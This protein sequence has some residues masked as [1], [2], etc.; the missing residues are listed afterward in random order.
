MK[1]LDPPV[2]QQDYSAYAGRWIASIGDQIIG[3][4]GT[5]TQALRAAQS[6][7]YKEVPQ[8]SYVPPTPPLK[9]HPILEELASL[10]PPDTPVYVVGGAVRDALLK[11]QVT[12]LDFILQNNAIKQA[13]KVADHFGGAFYVLDGERDYGRAMIPQ[14]GSQTL[15]MDF[16]PFQGRDLET[17]LLLR[18][19]TINAVA[20]GI[21][22]PYPIHDP[23]GGV[24][25]MLAKRLRACSPTA[26]SS[27]PIRVL[28]GIRF[29]INYDLRAEKETK[30]QMKASA[31]M[32]NNSSAER[33]RDELFK[34]LESKKPAAAIE[35]LD[36]LGGLEFVLPELI[37]LK[38]INQSAPHI[39]DAWQ[40]TL[41]VVR[42]LRSIWNVLSTSY[43]PDSTSNLFMGVLTQRL[44]R[45]R[46]QL[47]DHLDNNLVPYRTIRAL[48]ILAALYHDSGKPK[49]QEIEK[50]G[51]ARFIN[52]EEQ[53]ANIISKR[54]LKLHL[55]NSEIKRLQTIVH[56]HM[57]PLWL[58]QSGDLPSRR[59]KFRFFHD[60]NA[61]GVD[62]CLLSLADTLGTY[63]HTLT[64]E[65]WNHQVDVVRE[66]LEAWWEHQ[67]EQIFPPPLIDGN[68]LMN[69]FNLQP[70]P[71]IGRL[72]EELREAQATGKVL[73]QRQ[74]FEHI[75]HLLGEME[76]EQEAN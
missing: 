26:I 75:N 25:D 18:D 73:N 9:I 70:G 39:D 59:A 51:Q 2:Q 66:L 13:R 1:E 4:G 53:G 65:V 52:H 12:E 54:A 56:H 42:S 17:D 46:K 58:A 49:C 33:I 19:F 24:Q 35:V 47:A 41:S 27:D 57:R 36:S 69:E 76:S 55:S 3:Q 11:R 32:I 37:E 5:P 10:F 7:R 14:A 62:I 28:R 48:N 20:V 38:E 45:Y 30:Q 50:D 74:A 64:P 31:S 40:H 21:F 6:S 68:D 29:S 16:T 61:A 71:L 23:L 44:G 15:G 34:L 43:D 63:G 8:I 72:I 67:E 60:T 22:P